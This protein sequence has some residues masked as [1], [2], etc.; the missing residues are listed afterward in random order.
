[1]V[2]NLNFINRWEQHDRTKC[3]SGTPNGILTALYEICNVIDTDIEYKFYDK[4]IL[5][6]QVLKNVLF[7][8]DDFGLKRIHI[9]EKRIP[10][11]KDSIPALVFQEYIVENMNDMYCYIDCSVDFIVRL[12]KAHPELS[13]YTPYAENSPQEIIDERLRRSKIFIEN[14]KGYFTMS[15]W[16][17]KDLINESKIDPHKVHYVGGGCNVEINSVDISAKN[18]KRFLF[19]GKDW[20]RKNGPLVVKAFIHLIKKYHDLE[21]YIVGPKEKPEIIKNIPNINFIGSI[22]YD[23]V[24]YYYNLC[25]YFV[26]PSIFEAYGLVF[27]EALIFGLPCIG[28]NRYAMPEFIEQDENGL[29]LMNDDVEELADIMEKIYLHRQYYK[30]KVRDKFEYYKE[31]YSWKK[32]VSRMESC[33]ISDGYW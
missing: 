14:N 12:N 7:C 4:I 20:K 10:R 6:N 19:V 2:R 24:K 18:G 5:K 32:V 27:A 28:A 1:M 3:W 16:L 33:F 13:K 8:T 30:K 25:D 21:L 15:K 11:L 22:N 26:M 9:D 17:E 31:E 23:E 29:L